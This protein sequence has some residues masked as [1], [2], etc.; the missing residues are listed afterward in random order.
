MKILGIL[1]G[2]KHMA[3]MFT[4]MVT[5]D[6]NGNLERSSAA[7]SLCL[8]EPFCRKFRHYLYS[9]DPY[10]T[11]RRTTCVARRDVR[12]LDR[13]H[14]DSTVLHDEPFIGVLLHHRS[15]WYGIRPV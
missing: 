14:D 13:F 3:P 6:P 12:I 5:C 15:K 9:E 10:F 1:Y 8:A 7:F 11:Y 2:L 4:E